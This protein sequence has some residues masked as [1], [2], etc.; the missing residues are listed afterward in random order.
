MRFRS[1]T[2]QPGQKSDRLCLI[3]WYVPE[4]CNEL[5]ITK[6]TY[7][8]NIPYYSYYFI[9]QNSPA[10]PGPVYVNDK[11]TWHDNGNDVYIYYDGTKWIFGLNVNSMPILP[12]YNTI[13]FIN[14]NGDCDCPTGTWQQSSSIPNQDVYIT[15]ELKY[16]IEY[17]G[18]CIN[19]VCP[20]IKNK[21]KSV[22]P[23]YNTPGCESWK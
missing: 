12:V 5:I 22:T 7:I 19:G 2:L 13:G 23:C 4:L 6:T 1:L 11:P 3:R 16:T 21:Q 14:C 9:F 15:T 8:E 10:Y 18:N 20:P 17:F